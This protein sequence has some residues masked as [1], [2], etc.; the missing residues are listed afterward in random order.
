MPREGCQNW[1]PSYYLGMARPIAT[2]FDVCLETKQQC[3]LITQVID[4]EQL[5]VRACSCSRKGAR[6]DMPLYGWA[7]CV[8]IWSVLKD[9]L[10]RRFAKV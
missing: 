5:H 7:N 10:A 2:K 4:G 8:E 9:P 3:A 6:A 1:Q